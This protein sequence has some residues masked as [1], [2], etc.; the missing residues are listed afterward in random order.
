[1]T[2]PNLRQ[3]ILCRAG[4]EARYCKLDNNTDADGD[5]DGYVSRESVLTTQRFWAQQFYEQVTSLRPNQLQGLLSEPPPAPSAETRRNPRL[6]RIN[7]PL[8]EEKSVGCRSTTTV[9]FL[10]ST[11]LLYCTRYGTYWKTDDPCT[12]ALEQAEPRCC[13]SRR[14]PCSTRRYRG[15]LA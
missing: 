3:W 13:G 10:P 8:S 14:K 9:S 4:E 6:N 2:E 1:M 15:A 11:L 5:G 12:Q 7:I